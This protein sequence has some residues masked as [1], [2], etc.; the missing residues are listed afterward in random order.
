MKVFRDTDPAF[1]TDDSFSSK[2]E[3]TL[4]KMERVRKAKIWFSV[5]EAL[6][7]KYLTDMGGRDK[8]SED[9]MY[10]LWQNVAPPGTPYEPLEKIEVTE[11]MRANIKAGREWKPA[12]PGQGN[13]E[14]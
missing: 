14:R 5:S 10:R 4:A 8:T 11:E 12:G 1:T 7:E 2:E 3:E 6:R 9:V 13:D